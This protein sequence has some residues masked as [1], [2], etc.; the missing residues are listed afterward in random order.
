MTFSRSEMFLEKYSTCFI[1]P[2]IHCNHCCRWTPYLI[3]KAVRRR[4][5]Y[6]RREVLQTQISARSHLAS[7]LTHKD[8]PLLLS[9]ITP[10]ASGTRKPCLFDSFAH[11][12]SERRF[13]L[14]EGFRRVFESEICTV[15][16]YERAECVREEKRAVTHL[17]RVFL[18]ELPYQ[19]SMRR[20]KSAY[21]SL[22]SCPHDR[23]Q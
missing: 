16:H 14:G 4:Y 1:S 11:L 22:S 5:F 13:C 15:L 6:S 9:S 23:P 10:C 7:I 8:N 2:L 3:R 21:C 12:H 20:S 18:C 19:L 17:G